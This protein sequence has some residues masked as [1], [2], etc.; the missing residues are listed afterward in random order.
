M[1]GK[2][3]PSER[4]VLHYN[5]D[6][7]TAGRETT[8]PVPPGYI[9]LVNYET[10]VKSVAEAVSLALSSRFTPLL[11]KSIENDED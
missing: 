1:P 9:G 11:N 3:A 7:S 4:V 2:Y 6:E 5:L 8:D 10:V